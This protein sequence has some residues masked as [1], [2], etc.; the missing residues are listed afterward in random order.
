MQ[1]GQKRREADRERG[2]PG[3]PDL[4]A[5]QVYPV[6]VALEVAAKLPSSPLLAVE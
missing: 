4:E 1:V 6:A 2:V 5:V 3:V